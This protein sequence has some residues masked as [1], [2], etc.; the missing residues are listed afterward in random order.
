MELAS[1]GANVRALRGQMGSL[2]LPQLLPR[3]KYGAGLRIFPL[4]ICLSQFA[5]VRANGAGLHLFVGASDWHIRNPPTRD[6][7]IRWRANG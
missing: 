5:N 2:S 4:N 6:P 3:C 1:L 7:G